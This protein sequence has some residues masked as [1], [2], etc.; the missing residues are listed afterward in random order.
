MGTMH[1]SLERWR[2]DTI[3]FVLYQSDRQTSKGELTEFKQVLPCE[4]FVNTTI[5]YTRVIS[6]DKNVPKIFDSSC[7]TSKYY[8]T[9]HNRQ[10]NF[11]CASFDRNQNLGDCRQQS[12]TRAKIQ[13]R[14]SPLMQTRKKFKDQ[15]RASQ[16]K[17]YTVRLSWLVAQD[18]LSRQWTQLFM[19]QLWYR[20]APFFSL[21]PTATWPC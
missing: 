3:C 7:A 5:L 2:V 8:I 18:S 4:H 10:Q 20:C 21:R 17:Q 9:K 19:K 12:P 14:I 6:C 16:P 15:T 11:G 13:P 1:C